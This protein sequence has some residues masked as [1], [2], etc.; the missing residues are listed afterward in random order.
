MYYLWIKIG[1]TFQGI[2]SQ[3]N[4]NIKIFLNSSACLFI[5]EGQ[6]EQNAEAQTARETF[7][8]VFYLSYCQTLGSQGIT[9]SVDE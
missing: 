3:F 9:Q 2:K 6:S 8:K 5:V 1:I 4:C 7:L